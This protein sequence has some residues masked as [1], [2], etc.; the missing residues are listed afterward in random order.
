[1]AD[2]KTPIVIDGVD[3]NFEDL[4]QDQQIFVNHCA[5]LDRKIGTTQFNLDQLKVGK[6]AFFAMLKKSL[7]EAKAADEPSII[8]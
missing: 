1:M 3:Y 7:D 4:T 2:K 6:E 8:V 5:D